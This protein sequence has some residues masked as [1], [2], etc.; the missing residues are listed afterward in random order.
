[1]GNS[2]IVMPSQLDLKSK[3]QYWEALKRDLP[4]VTFPLLAS[5]ELVTATI[6]ASRLTFCFGHFQQH[7][8]CKTRGKFVLQGPLPQTLLDLVVKSVVCGVFGPLFKR[9]FLPTGLHHV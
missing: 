2:A 6:I 7:P 8:L 4:N 5:E 3:W 9:E 1:M